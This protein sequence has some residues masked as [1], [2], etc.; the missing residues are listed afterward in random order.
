MVR[1]DVILCSLPPLDLSMSVSRYGK[2][3]GIPVIIDV[4]DL[5]PD[6]FLELVPH[7]GR[8]WFDLALAPLWR[9][10]RSSCRNAFAITGNCPGFVE[11]GLGHAGRSGTDLD[12]HFP[13]GYSAPKLSVGEREQAMRF[14]GKHGLR[15]GDGEFTVCFFGAF[16]KQF[17]LETVIDAAM[18]LEAEGANVRFVLC[19]TGERLEGL[20][21]RARGSNAVI[22]PGWV[23]RDQIWTL[24]A[25]S[26][27]GI[28]PYRNHP[29]F[30][31][32][33][34]NKPI[35]YM[36]GGL[37][38][39]SGLHGYLE[40]LLVRYQCG[41]SYAPGDARALRNVVMR[42]V[43]DRTFLN[44]ISTNARRLFSE[45]FDADKVY[46]EMIRYLQEVVSVYST[47]THSH[48]E[49]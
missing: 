49:T 48:L 45:N 14:W 9:Q 40:S 10:A 34:P 7:W 15:E 12:R 41:L 19:G 32:N 26:D 39:I 27:A 2:T 43:D 13:F 35:E 3:N 44:G 4:R 46:G 25:L 23:G 37:P 5:W 18:M 17:D 36:A 29:G 8:T 38:I 21:I 20:K 24:M 31:N 30:V 6:I 16:G 33:L 47:R 28:A 1:P 11:W 42:L 22:F